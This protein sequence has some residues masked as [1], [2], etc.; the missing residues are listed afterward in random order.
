MWSSEKDSSSLS[1]K[2]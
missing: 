1:V 2:K